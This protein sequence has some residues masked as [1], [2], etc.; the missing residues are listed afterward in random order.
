MSNPWYQDKPENMSVKHLV[1]VVADSPPALGDPFKVFSWESVWVDG[2][3]MTN[4]LKSSLS[5][6]Y[7]IS[8]VSVCMMVRTALFETNLTNVIAAWT[9]GCSTGSSS[10]SSRRLKIG[11]ILIATSSAIQSD[12][13]K[14]TLILDWKCYNPWQSLTDA[15]DSK[16]VSTTTRVSATFCWAFGPGKKYSLKYDY[17]IR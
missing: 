2:P 15:A 5:W 6:K 9:N 8:I 7:V 16:T 13:L 4:V 12:C 11:A 1:D 14:N 10:G 3:V 17:L